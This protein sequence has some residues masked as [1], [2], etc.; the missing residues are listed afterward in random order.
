MIAM[1]HEVCPI[2]QFVSLNPPRTEK[3][4]HHNFISF[5]KLFFYIFLIRS[6]MQMVLSCLALVI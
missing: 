5:P 3:A 1:P 6:I 2:A 4:M